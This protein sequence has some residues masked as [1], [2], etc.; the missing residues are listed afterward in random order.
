MLLFLARVRS[1]D[2]NVINSFAKILWCDSFIRMNLN[3]LKFNANLNALHTYNIILAGVTSK[4][5][6]KYFNF[7]YNKS[8]YKKRKR[9]KKV[10]VGNI[11]IYIN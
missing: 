5:E 7:M 9:E 2:Y 4:I 3:I 8:A 11:Y 10:K 1:N 6:N